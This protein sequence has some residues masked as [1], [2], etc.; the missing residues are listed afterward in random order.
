MRATTLQPASMHKQCHHTLVL[1]HKASHIRPSWRNCTIDTSMP[2]KLLKQLCK[3][4]TDWVIERTLKHHMKLVAN[5]T[6]H[7]ML[8]Q[9]LPSRHTRKPDRKSTRL[10]S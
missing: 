7:A 8:T 10:N 9:P 1:T 6:R 4:A 5:G 3:T 2:T